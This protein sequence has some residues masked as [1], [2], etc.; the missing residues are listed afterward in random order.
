MSRRRWLPLI[1]L[2]VTAV[3]LIPGFAPADEEGAKVYKDLLKSICW[4]HS[5]RTGGKVATGTGSLVDLDRRLVLTNY[6]VVGDRDIVKV[7][8][9]R[10]E[11]GKVVAE[12]DFYRDRFRRYGIV[13][14]V[15]YRDKKADLAL[16][17]LEGLPEGVQAIK[18]APE[19]A[20]AGQSVHSVGNPGDSGALWVYTP[21]KVRQVYHKKW[22]AKMGDDVADFEADIVET[23]SATN[24][25]D[26]GGPLVNDKGQLVGVTQGGAIGARLL[27]TFIDVAEVKKT[28]GT[29]A[30]KN[31]AAPAK[32]VKPAGRTVVVKD[33]AKFF[34]EETIKKVTEEVRE[35]ARKYDRDVL[36]ETYLKPP[37]DQV[38][39]VK[40]MSKEDRDK[41]FKKWA[42]ERMKAEGL[43][44][45][46]ILVCKE[47]SYLYVEASNRAKTIFDREFVDKLVKELL[48]N[49][50]KKEFDGGLMAAVKMVGEKLAAEVKR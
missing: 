41:F 49:F 2:P 31:I 24:P 11:K 29:R 37:D 42:E 10:T 19:S 47:P 16:V 14:K 22:K 3:V 45:V 38:D 43:A 27:S 1:A 25:G 5:P 18:L 32:T 30:A 44:G 23:D 34:S 13:G 7:M 15:V 40:E 4:I 50:R 33:D 8:F 46:Y 48:S 9:P 36:V 20:E 21:G 6:H 28:L 35:L 12:R 26:S 17:Q 39:K